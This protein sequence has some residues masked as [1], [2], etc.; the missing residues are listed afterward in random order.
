MKKGLS[1]SSYLY[2]GS[3]LFGLFFGAGNL[4]FPVHM[5]QVAGANVS[6]ATLGFLVTGIGL[7]FLGVIAIGISKSNG[8]FDLASRIHPYYGYFMT[9]AL[10]LTIGPFFALPRLSTVSYEIGL[11]PYIN[12]AYQT[13]GLAIFSILFYGT[14]LFLSLKPTKILIYVG[15]VLNPIFLVFLGVLIVTA[16]IRPL[17][18]VMD[19]SVTGSYVAQ[20]FVSGFLEG[21]N[22]MDALASL[23]FGIVVVQTIKTLGV[24]KPSE[25]AKDTIKSGLISILLMGIIYASLAYIGTMSVG[26]FPV[27]EN[28][29]IALAQISNYYFGSFG[30]VLLAV[31]VTVACLKTA[32]GLITACAETFKEMFP[33]S[34]SYKAYVVVFSVLTT[35]VANIG[36]TNI[37]AFSLPVLM[38]LY[39]L[40]ITLILLALLSPLFKDRQ[41]VYVT[42]TIFTL[43]VSVADLL[44]ALPENIRNL[45]GIQN[46]LTFCADYLPLFSMGMGWILPATIGFVVGIIISLVT[47][48]N[49]R[50]L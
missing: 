38:F 18:G 27:S 32:I 8:L 20:P 29:G 45:N 3:M 35:L 10:Y 23:A 19:A 48:P 30:S 42:T 33:R 44:N 17:G 21:Y 13:V 39:P 22:T 49:P 2:I 26:Q 47:K 41:V 36:L 11:T 15:K 25:I 14:A 1:L 37:I 40:A 24:T 31:I 7:P 46:F 9:I 50:A 6:W 28:G 16:F 34:I 5:G 43:V 12:P 4:I